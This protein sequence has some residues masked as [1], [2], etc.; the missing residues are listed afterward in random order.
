MDVD[1]QYFCRNFVAISFFSLL[2]SLCKSE[3]GLNV[4]SLCI[5]WWFFLVLI[6]GIKRSV[7]GYNL[8]DP[9]SQVSVRIV[10]TIRHRMQYNN[11]LSV[12]FAIGMLSTRGCYLLFSV[13]YI[14]LGKL[15]LWTLVYQYA[16]ALIG[17]SF[18]LYLKVIHIHFF[19]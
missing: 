15:H 8:G 11:L 10:H 12:N 14:V 4:I 2:I 7:N 6:F 16:S 17:C 3:L 19:R 5:F 13:K 1:F 18:N 9:I